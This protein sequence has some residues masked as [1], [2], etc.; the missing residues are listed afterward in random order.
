MA[1][2]FP[3]IFTICKNIYKE[4]VLKTKTLPI[5]INSTED[6]DFTCFVVLTYAF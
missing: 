4:N 6:L 5:T 3:Q 1:Q 2:T